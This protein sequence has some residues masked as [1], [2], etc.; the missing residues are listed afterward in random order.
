M[1]T[2][3]IMNSHRTCII[4][5]P[6]SGSQLCEMLAAEVQDALQ[7]G[8]YFENWNRSEY[9]LDENN[10]IY[11]KTTIEIKSKLM[12]RNNF[13]ESISLLKKANPKQSLTLRLFLMEYYNKDV[14]LKILADLKTIGFE[15]ITLHRN[16]YEQILS[17]MITLS[18]FNFK[19]KN[20][21]GITSDI[22]EPV[23]VNFNILGGMLDD[24][25]IS[26]KKWEHNLSTILNNTE[27]KKVKYENIYADMEKI[28]NIKFK[29]VGKKSIKVNPLDLILNKE[30][31]VNFLSSR[32][33]T[34]RS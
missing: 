25:A 6:R 23:H 2:N 11:L 18:Y 24:L 32:I 33:E 34:I 15:F 26:S 27:Y 16:A 22:D 12:I 19:N 30:E 13:E 1:L 7:L 28:Y 8:E 5:L 20:V 14:L 21:F 9:T 3:I 31:V 17:F 29:Y 4:C 10:N